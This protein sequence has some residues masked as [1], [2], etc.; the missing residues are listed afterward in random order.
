MFLYIVIFF[1]VSIFFFNKKAVPI[2][3][4]HQVNPLSNVKPELF[5]EHLKIIK[6]LK[7]N[8]VTISE[9]YEKK[10]MNNSILLTFDDGYFD[11]YK[12]VFPLLKK[13]NMKATIFLNTLYIKNKREN[14]PE[15]LLNYDANYKAIENFLKDKNSG[16]EQY[17]TWEEIKEMYD[18]GL[19]DFQAHSHKHTA[20]FTDKKISGFTK[21]EK[22]DFT[23]LY[24]YG[25]VSDNY[26]IF[27]KRGEYSA[28][29]VKIKKDFFNIFKAYFENNLANIKEY[30][31]QL[32]LAQNFIENNI[33]FFEKETEEEYITRIT[34]D[35][36]QN[37]NLIEKNLGNRIHFF[38][39]PWG[40]RSKEAIKILK[41]LGVKGFITTK[42]GTNLQNPNW[43]MIRRIELRN[44]NIRKFYLNILIA[45]NCILGEIYGWLS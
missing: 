8:T 35:F 29:A 36:I 11:N 18:S 17:M 42:K 33:E 12:Y 44:Y 14:D 24:L 25:N 43:D 31:E 27:P 26:P 21:K 9:Y 13:Y 2:F 38:C 23:D 3:L 41:D 7:M 22:M 16:S 28:R 45:R 5:E 1:I 15:I 32:K 4:Y 6:N 19:I 20:I 40:H 34:N 10:I 30:K 39:W 37:K